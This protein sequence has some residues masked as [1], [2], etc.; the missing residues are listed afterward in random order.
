MPSST[1]LDKLNAL[2]DQCEALMVAYLKP[3]GINAEEVM[4]RLIDLCD[5]PEWRE[6]RGYVD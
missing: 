5:G 6:T 2:L 3:D 4:V 1:N